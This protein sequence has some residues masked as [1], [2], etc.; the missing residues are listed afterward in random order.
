MEEIRKGCKSL[1]VTLKIPAAYVILK[2]NIN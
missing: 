2:K 1:P